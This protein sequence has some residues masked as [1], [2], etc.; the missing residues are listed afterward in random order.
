MHLS[1]AAADSLPS[2]SVGPVESVGEEVPLVCPSCSKDNL[3]GSDFCEDCGAQLSPQADSGRV[4]VAVR[5]LP[6]RTGHVLQSRYTITRLQNEG[7]YNAYA[8]QDAEG[9]V[10]SLIEDVGPRSPSQSNLSSAAETVKKLQHPA[11]WRAYGGFDEN[12]RSYLV[13][14]VLPENNLTALSGKQP[15][16]FSER[17]VQA[18]FLQLLHGL[19]HLHSQGFLHRSVFPSNIWL[20]VDGRVILAGLERLCSLANPPADFEVLEGFSPPEAYGMVGGKIDVRSDI[21]SIG[22]CMYYA[23]AGTVPS[24]EKREQFFSFPRLSTFNLEVDAMLEEIILKAV[25]KDPKLR[26]PT[27][28]V[29]AQMLEG[30]NL[31]DMPLRDKSGLATTPMASVFASGTEAEAPAAGQSP[32]PPEDEA[33]AAT[34]VPLDIEVGRVTNVGMV[35]EVNQDSLLA[36]EWTAYER[37]V[38]T[39]GALLV[40]ADGMGGEAEGD[41]ASSLAIRALA[42]YVLGQALPIKVGNE[43]ARLHPTVALERLGEMLINGLREANRTVNGYAQKDSTRRG[44]GSTVTAAVIDGSLL[45]IGHAGDTRAY[46]FRDTVEQITED[47][48]LVGKLVKMGQMTRDEALHSPQR[49]LIYR[50]VGT[51]EIIDIDVYHRLLKPGDWL[52]I[53]CDGVW[54]YFTDNELTQIFQAGTSAQQ[55]ANELVNR[56][57]ARGADDNCTAI[58]VR[59]SAPVAV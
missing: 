26:F 3:P 17:A 37:S 31:T 1:A 8:A 47:H 19:E 24:L 16:R 45:V 49:S 20:G 27:V 44:M 54:E 51:Q 30:V 43:T 39:Q 55:V 4:A 21:Y 5:E 28:G 46:I 58:V 9:P 50:A 12:G 18:M 59:L 14:D 40:V 29:M 2:R 32:P 35:R 22:A 57:L 36:L 11:L 23:L 15:G 38:P 10:V 48:S 53:C 56:C 41:K 25:S 7:R 52:L 42:S 33:T 34:K 6:L 13:G